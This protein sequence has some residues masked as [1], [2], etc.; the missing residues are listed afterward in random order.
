MCVRFRG[1]KTQ[2]DHF[3][4]DPIVAILGGARTSE[5][6]VGDTTEQFLKRCPPAVEPERHLVPL[7]QST[8]L[9]VPFRL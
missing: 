9:P 4:C 6:S 3:A 2:S 8:R 1:V 7:G 5:I